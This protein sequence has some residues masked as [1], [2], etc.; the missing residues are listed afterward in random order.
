MQLK[1]RKML[2]K[3][4]LPLHGNIDPACFCPQAA[5]LLLHDQNMLSTLQ[6]PKARPCDVRIFDDDVAVFQPSAKAFGPEVHALA[7]F[8]SMNR[9]L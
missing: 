7:T 5:G 9:I 1:C 8:R 3:A 6:R 2:Y 4:Y